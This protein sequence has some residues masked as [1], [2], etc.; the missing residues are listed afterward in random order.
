MRETGGLPREPRRG[1]IGRPNLA[2]D[3]KRSPN[4]LSPD[5]PLAGWMHLYSDEVWDPHPSWGFHQEPRPGVH[6]WRCLQSQS[7]PFF[8]PESSSRLQL[9]V[10]DARLP[11]WP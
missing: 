7:I 10:A 1:L 3:Q 6:R 2:V 11:C 4:A 5:A 8:L 9:R